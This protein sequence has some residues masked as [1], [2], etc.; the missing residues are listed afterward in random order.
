MSWQAYRAAQ[1]EGHRHAQ[2]VG[3][4]DGVM[5]LPAVSF[6]Q[7]VAWF[8]QVTGQLPSPWFGDTVGYLGGRVLVRWDWMIDGWSAT[9]RSLSVWCRRTPLG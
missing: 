5:R 8:N 3:L 2:E 9:M 1:A 4:T 6:T 7:W